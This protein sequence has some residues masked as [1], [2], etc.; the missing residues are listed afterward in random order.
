MEASIGDVP[1]LSGS[2][3]HAVDQLGPVFVHDASLDLHRGRE[4]AVVLIEFTRKHAE[5]A[6]VLDASKALVDGIDVCLNARLE[7]CGVSAGCAELL[8]VHGDNRGEELV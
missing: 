2:V 7:A 8:G 5:L 4:F 6:H 3:V 1:M